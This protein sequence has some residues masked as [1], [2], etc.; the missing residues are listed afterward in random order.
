[1]LRIDVE[2]MYIKGNCLSMFCDPKHGN[3]IVE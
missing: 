3:G 2:K 1:M